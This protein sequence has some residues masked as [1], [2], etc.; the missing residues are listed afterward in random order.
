MPE[1][2]ESVE[3]N[4]ERQSGHRLTLKFQGATLKEC[5][6]QTKYF[7]RAFQYLIKPSWQLAISQLFLSIIPLTTFF[8]S[9]RHNYQSLLAV[10][11]GTSLTNVTGMSVCYAVV[12]ACEELATVSDKFK[13][14]ATI[15][16]RAL[17]FTIAILF[18]PIWALWLNAESIFRL[19]YSDKGYSS[20]QEPFI[21]YA[22]HYVFIFIPG[23]LLFL[24]LILLQKYM[25][26]IDQKIAI[27]ILIFNFIGVAINFGLN[28]L[29]VLHV[30]PGPRGSCLATILTY[31][32]ITML[33][34]L[35][36]MWRNKLK[37][38]WPG[39]QWG[40]LLD[41]GAFSLKF[42]PFLLY[43]F[44][45][46]STLDSGII[47]VGRFEEFYRSRSVQMLLCFIV[48]LLSMVS[49]QFAS[50][51]SDQII[52]AIR[53]GYK[54]RAVFIAKCTMLIMWLG[55]IAFGALL[56]GLEHTLTEQF[57]NNRP[58]PLSKA[59]MIMLFCPIPF[60]KGTQA[61][62]YNL[63]RK[64][65]S[66]YAHI[67]AVLVGNWCISLPISL[68]LVYWRKWNIQGIWAGYIIGQ[69]LQECNQA[70]PLTPSGTL[71]RTQEDNDFD[72]DA[73]DGG[74]GTKSLLLRRPRILM[75]FNSVEI[76][77]ENEGSS[78]GRQDRPPVR[79]LIIRVIQ[80]PGRLCIR[81]LVYFPPFSNLHMILLHTSKANKSSHQLFRKP[82]NAKAKAE[83]DNAEEKYETPDQESQEYFHD[84][85]E[86]HA[87]KKDKLLL[88][89]DM[90]DVIDDN[91]EYSDDGDDEVMHIDTDEEDVDNG[92]DEEDDDS[93]NNEED[94]E[95]LEQG[96]PSSKAWGRKKSQFY[97]SDIKDIDNIGN[98]EEEELA[99]EE[100][101]KEALTLQQRMISH[102]S[103]E[104]F[105][106]FDVEVEPEDEKDADEMEEESR[107]TKDL[108]KLSKDEMIE[109][110]LKES[111]EL[112]ELMDDYEVKM[113]E[114]INK[115]HPLLRL[116]R[117]GTEF[118]SE[119]ISK[120][121]ERTKSF[122]KEIE[123]LLVIAKDVKDKAIDD[124]KSGKREK[125]LS[126]DV[127]K[128][129]SMKI[130]DLASDTKKKPKEKQQKSI[131]KESESKRLSTIDPLEYYNKIANET[132]AKKMAKT[133]NMENVI[134]KEDDLQNDEDG[135][136]GI[137]YEMSKNKGLT[138]KRK[139]ELKNPR[140]KHKM[141]FKKAIV[142]RKSQI[143][144]VRGEAGNYGGELTG[145][146]TNVRKSVKIK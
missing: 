76:V 91:S 126:N 140:V 68:C 114:I 56:I 10:G 77:N 111:P 73:V 134:M 14:A 64:M 5:Q 129:K 65:G 40:L 95:G 27:P 67:L 125:S 53:G 78:Q 6:Q 11:L 100:E 84:E 32:T 131:E 70:V 87:I 7:T 135:K 59:E 123:E 47:I 110:L 115:Y 80:L 26:L 12:L 122:H 16:Q 90:D 107:V 144:L 81:M 102:L 66:K 69:F 35:Y 117:K 30:I 103:Q 28:A 136:R 101:E 42:L 93:D 109:I 43:F 45:E 31:L 94:D 62:G 36:I 61:I 121:E 22:G 58:F 44:A 18:L 9:S 79:L 29:F 128:S 138:R 108:L 25:Y 34:F 20:T 72:E 141:K 124:D 92:I 4:S 48:H 139:K 85:I 24:L 137:T 112:F 15:I 13:D 127:K 146:K 88:D 74:A 130:T 133:M 143:P 17:F 54:Q 49:H 52:D 99:A 33:S 55:G 132:K 89:A 97:D 145:I 23:L 82:K 19:L 105:D 50:E 57:L 83:G 86:Q 41:W 39:W 38:A 106:H 51:A 98:D 3:R 60:L 116:A 96:L 2:I 118:T 120:Y 119:L 37:A 46:W 75:R 21:G 8:F 63:M 113:N 1:N 104:D 71:K 142:R